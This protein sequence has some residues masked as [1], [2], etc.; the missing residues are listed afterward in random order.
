MG[1]LFVLLCFIFYKNVISVAGM[2]L[3]LLLI[4]TQLPTPST[5]FWS[6]LFTPL[7][8]SGEIYLLVRIWGQRRGLHSPAGGDGSRLVLTGGG[9]VEG[10]GPDAV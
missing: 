3:E 6:T 7:V 10:D 4:N 5:H 8:R 2:L 9:G 1:V